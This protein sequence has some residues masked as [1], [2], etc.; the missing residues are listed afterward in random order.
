MA[1][2][3]DP[4]RAE[5]VKYL[6]PHQ[7][8]LAKKAAEATAK[9]RSAL[10]MATKPTGEKMVTANDRVEREGGKGGET[11]VGGMKKDVK[12]KKGG[13]AQKVGDVGAAKEMR[14]FVKG[15]EPKEPVSLGEEWELVT[16]EDEDWELVGK[17]DMGERRFAS[18]K[19]V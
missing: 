13:E 5:Y 17:G 16:A 7:K 18:G 9:A 6:A 1:S 19:A 11:K 4:S 15:A 8:L 10:A 14:V 12:V 3:T 2:T